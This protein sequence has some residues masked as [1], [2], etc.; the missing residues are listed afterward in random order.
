MVSTPVDGLPDLVENGKNGYP[1][2]GWKPTPGRTNTG[3]KY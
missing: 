3:K 2:P 1:A